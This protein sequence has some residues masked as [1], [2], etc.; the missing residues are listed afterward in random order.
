MSRYLLISFPDSSALHKV[1]SVPRIMY[2]PQRRWA[3]LLFAIFDAVVGEK[4]SS[5]KFCPTCPNNSQ[6]SSGVLNSIR[7]R[8]E[9]AI[10]GCAQATAGPYIIKDWDWSGERGLASLHS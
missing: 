6:R 1:A 7:G 9:C 3:H 2:C 4:F 5:V 10:L 8:H